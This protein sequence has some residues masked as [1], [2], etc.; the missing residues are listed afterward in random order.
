MLLVENFLTDPNQD[1]ECH[2][3]ACAKS[4]GAGRYRP[5]APVRDC[6]R[7][8]C[9]CDLN[10]CGTGTHGKGKGGFLSDLEFILHILIR[11]HNTGDSWL[12]AGFADEGY[13]SHATHWKI[14]SAY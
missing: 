7:V 4:R 9:D 13:I 8:E 14:H 11:P 5:G 3:G 6:R 10:E 2:G 1:R 12:L